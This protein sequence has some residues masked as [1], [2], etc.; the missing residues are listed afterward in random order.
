LFESGLPTAKSEGN[1]GYSVAA[2]EP[3]AGAALE[4]GTRVA[5]AAHTRA[6]SFGGGIEG[7][8]VAVPGTVAPD[9]VGVEL[10]TA[11]APVRDGQVR[12]VAQKEVPVEQLMGRSGSWPLFPALIAPELENVDGDDP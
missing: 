5:L 10:E 8:T 9:V 12:V 7:R 11:M 3:A 6:L 4:P 1:L 2:Q